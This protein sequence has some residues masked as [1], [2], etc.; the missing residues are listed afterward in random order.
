M[1]MEDLDPPREQAGAAHGI[2]HSLRAHGLEWDGAVLWQSERHAAYDSVIDDL[3]A[4]GL[5]FRC[6]CSRRSLAASGGRY[7]GHCRERGLAADSN[8]A[9]R[10]RIRENTRIS[11]HDRLQL[12]LEQD[13]ARDVGDFVIRRRDRLAAYQLAVVI[14]DAWQGVTHVVRGS[15]L[16][17]STPRQVY[18]Q[19]LLGLPT[20]VYT[21]IP[22]LTNT[23]GYKLSKQ[24]FAAAVDNSRPAH[25]LR[26]ALEF[27]N[28]TRPPQ[29]L[30]AVTEILDWA[31]R[32]WQAGAIPA[33]L[34]IPESCA[35]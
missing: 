30:A 12:T 32:H 27:L 10:I 9:V 3:L 8:H 34:Q 5:A 22:V 29:E 4:R 35:D 28:Q 7:T 1:R 2:L 16:Y 24:T 13:L 19:R 14:D 23:E 6:D 20:P 33:R 18:L 11:V 31:N 26:Q 25:N 21:H 17:D 15:D